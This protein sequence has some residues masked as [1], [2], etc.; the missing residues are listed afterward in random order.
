MAKSPAFQWYPKDILSSVRV[1]E[2]SLAEEGAYRRLIDFCWLNGS[3]PADPIRASRVV[4]KG[5][6]REITEAVL[7]MFT[8]D[9]NDPTRLI[10]DR[11]EE[12]RRRQEERSVKC[13]ASANARWGGVKQG[14]NPSGNK[15]VK[16]PIKAKCK[17]NA[18]ALQ[19]KC[20]SSST[21]S[22]NNIENHIKENSFEESVERIWQV[23][24]KKD[25]KKEGIK[26]IIKRLKEGLTE[27]YLIERV[28]AYA[29]CVQ[30]EEKRYIK[31]AQGW[32]NQERYLDEALDN[33]KPKAPKKS[34]REEIYE[35]IK[36]NKQLFKA[37][38]NAKEGHSTRLYGDY[39]SDPKTFDDWNWKDVVLDEIE[40]TPYSESRKVYNKYIG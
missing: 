33:P 8:P 39:T 11:L 34:K 36:S 5:C 19:T 23:Y 24:P 1:A 12:E 26:A 31:H 32:F 40:K 10:H 14:T 20:S 7:P 15:Q 18:N 13:S 37:L 28:K 9:P 21:S 16:T 30:G 25:G 35:N 27:E 29:I 6:T 3:I 38:F 4:G 22:S 17:R 2:M